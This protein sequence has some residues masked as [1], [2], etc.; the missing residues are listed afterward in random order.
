MSEKGWEGQSTGRQ[1]N[2]REPG[3]LARLA[4]GVGPA[5]AQRHAPAATTH[6]ARGLGGAREHVWGLGEGYRGGSRLRRAAQ[7]F[8]WDGWTGWGGGRGPTRQ[9]HGVSSRKTGP[10]RHRADVCGGGV[11][12]RK[13]GVAVTGRLRQVAKASP[14]R[15]SSWPSVLRQLALTR[16]CSSSWPPLSAAAAAGRPGCRGLRRRPPGSAGGSGAGC[17][18]AHPP[19]GPPAP[20]RG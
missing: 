7:G 4:S 19:R 6:A 11:R 13:S 15:G 2:G 20:G 10:T 9:A 1:R 17:E 5:S 16:R 12:G 18:G 3:W 8:W 14:Q